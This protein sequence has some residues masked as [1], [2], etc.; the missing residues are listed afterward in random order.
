MN[1]DHTASRNETLQWFNLNNG[2]VWHVTEEKA[3]LENSHRIVDGDLESAYRLIKTGSGSGTRDTGARR[4]G[5]IYM[6]RV[7][8]QLY[9][10]TRANV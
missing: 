8:F 4:M 10:D 9:P 2:R 5:G 3:I 7:I 1:R 6:T